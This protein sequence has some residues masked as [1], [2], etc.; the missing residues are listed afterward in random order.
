MKLR[1][2]C[3]KSKTAAT[4]E[5]KRK[6]FNFHIFNISS[7]SSIQFNY[8][9]NLKCIYNQAVTMLTYYQCDIAASVCHG[10]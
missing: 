9:F 2:R 1:K 7:Y 5:T 6:H 8:D 4:K 10:S 3:N